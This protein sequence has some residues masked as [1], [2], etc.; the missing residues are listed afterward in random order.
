MVERTM[1]GLPPLNPLR[2]FDA[3]GRLQSIRLP[4]GS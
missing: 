3:A 2:A 1:D 4:P